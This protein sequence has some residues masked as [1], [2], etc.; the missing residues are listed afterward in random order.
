MTGNNLSLGSDE[1]TRWLPIY[2]NSK[3]ARPQ[4]RTFKKPD[5]MSHALSIREEVLRDVVGIVAGYIASKENMP[6][7]NRYPR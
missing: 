4:E 2:L 7:A 5:V 1:L 3:S 6:T